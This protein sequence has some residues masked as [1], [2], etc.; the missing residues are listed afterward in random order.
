MVWC[1]TSPSKHFDTITVTQKWLVDS[2][3]DEIEGVKGRKAAKRKA[4]ME[5]GTS[6]TAGKSTYQ[7]RPCT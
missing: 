7:C 1:V 5:K 6:S 2:S 3:L 4:A